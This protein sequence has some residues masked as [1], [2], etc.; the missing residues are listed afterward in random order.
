M[1]THFSRYPDDDE[2]PEH[3]SCG[4]LL[5]ES[6]EQTS[7]W[8]YV[9]CLSCLQRKDK[10]MAHIESEERAIVDQMGDM[11]NFMR[12]QPAEPAEAQHHD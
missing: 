9:T 7:Q 3:A 4:T 8:A 11:A 1:K 10:I 2:Q 5:G 12:G 6:A